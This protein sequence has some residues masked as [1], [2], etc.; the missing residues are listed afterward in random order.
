MWSW[1]F[2]NSVWKGSWWDFWPC[3]HRKWI[4][5]IYLFTGSAIHWISSL[6]DI[7][8][9]TREAEMYR[10]M[11]DS[12]SPELLSICLHL[13]L[14]E[15]QMYGYEYHSVYGNWDKLVLMRPV[16]TFM[17]V[18]DWY[19][20]VWIVPF[21]MISLEFLYFI[22]IGINS[23]YQDDPITNKFKCVVFRKAITSL[24]IFTG[25]LSFNTFYYMLFY[26]FPLHLVTAFY[27]NIC[28]SYRQI[29]CFINYMIYSLSTISP[30]NY[31][32]NT[33]YY[34]LF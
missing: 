5:F 17:F 3:D 22:F 28:L 27:S 33:F 2:L 18:W 16:H 8:Q 29:I 4:D 25:K 7:W 15:I 1:R 19:V 31:S 34:L 14:C 26:N 13:C 24:Q 12:G 32:F 30:K 10:L 23:T 6:E 9:S 20:C 21:C 11:S